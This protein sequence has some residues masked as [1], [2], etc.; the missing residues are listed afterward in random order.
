MM[1]TKSHPARCCLPPTPRTSGT[2][3]RSCVVPTPRTSKGEA[4]ACPPAT[5]LKGE[6]GV[7]HPPAFAPPAQPW[8]NQLESKH[9]IRATTGYGRVK[10]VK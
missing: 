1:K 4:R 3:T 10:T 7:G 6:R 2:E 5:S 9:Y 8:A